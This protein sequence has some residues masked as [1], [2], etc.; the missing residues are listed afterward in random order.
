MRIDLIKKLSPYI[1]K[2]E[3]L[4]TTNFEDL[5][6]KIVQPSHKFDDI[7]YILKLLNIK[8]TEIKTSDK[9]TKFRIL[10]SNQLTVKCENDN[11]AAIFILAIVAKIVYGEQALCFI[12]Y[13][14]NS[15]KNEKL[16]VFGNDW[17]RYESCSNLSDAIPIRKILLMDVQ[18][19]NMK[20]FCD[21]FPNKYF[22]ED[23]F[24]SCL[25]YSKD[26]SNDSNDFSSNYNEDLFDGHSDAYWN[27]D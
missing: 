16:T 4:Q 20:K 11:F 26:Y 23:G 8:Y 1:N 27:I 3:N 2:L 17:K 5:H 6:V 7:S 21:L 19:M 13:A 18:E 10:N 22:S 9:R 24:I 25:E 14:K 12:S 15:N